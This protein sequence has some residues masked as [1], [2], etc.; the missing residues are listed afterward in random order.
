[1]ARASC[2]VVVDSLEELLS[3]QGLSGVIVTEPAS[4]RARIVQQCLSA[5]KDVWLE[6]PLSDDLRQVRRLQ[7]LARERRVAL[8]VLQTQRYDRDYRTALFALQSGRLG[9]LRS[10]RLVVAEWTTFAGDQGAEVCPLVDPV[11][12][13]APHGFDQLLGLVEGEPHWIWARRCTGEDGFL[14]VIGFTSGTTAQIE[15]RRR[16]RATMH[17]GWV[18]EGELAS[19]QQ[20]RIISVAQ[21][22]ELLEEQILP[23]DSVDDPFF[24]S[25]QKES[26]SSEGEAH[27]A[28][29][30]VGLMLAV[31]RSSLRGGTIRWDE[32]VGG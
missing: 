32:V 25:L 5:G 16:A 29:L 4:Q 21:D 24:S 12:Q 15:V 10:V 13:F 30:T 6:P 14:A 2:S 22:G 17:T 26:R 23:P 1:M 18:L 9:P 20:G 31:Q 11:E 27:R 28:W 3:T 7:S 19:Y 8:Q